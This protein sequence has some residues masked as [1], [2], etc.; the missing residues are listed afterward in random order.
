MRG[1]TIVATKH[2]NR[3]WTTKE[4]LALRE[5]GH[6][7]AAAVARLL[8]RSVTSVEKMAARQRISL[9]SDGERR[10]SVLGQPRGVSIIP[11]IRENVVSG[12]I[13]DEAIAERMRLHEDAST[14]PCCGRRP[15][16]VSST[17]FCGVCHKN[18]LIEAHLYELEKIDSQRSLWTSRTALCRARK[19]AEA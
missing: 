10:G 1:F 17:G 14:C 15:I 3:M 12:R 5:S 6:L 4:L 18:R 9:R 2:G 11:E 13:S 8:G 19:A 7:G 16:E